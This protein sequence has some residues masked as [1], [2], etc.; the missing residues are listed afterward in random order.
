MIPIADADKS[1]HRDQPSNLQKQ[2]I[3]SPFH[4]DFPFGFMFMLRGAV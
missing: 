3:G 1:K 2:T 4:R